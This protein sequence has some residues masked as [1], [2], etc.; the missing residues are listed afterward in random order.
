MKKKNS[1][2][3]NF[4]FYRIFSSKLISFHF[5]FPFFFFSS[6]IEKKLSSI[7]AH[8]HTHMH[9]YR[10]KNGSQEAE[11][12]KVELRISISSSKIKKISDERAC[13]DWKWIRRQI[14]AGESE[15]SELIGHGIGKLSEKR[16]SDYQLK[17]LFLLIRSH[18]IEMKKRSKKS[19]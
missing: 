5:L 3:R 12:E 7:H 16:L 1:K 6:G 10:G 2:S 11:A 13:S 4:Q 9:T 15:I 19:S 17:H 14:T 18:L 8:T